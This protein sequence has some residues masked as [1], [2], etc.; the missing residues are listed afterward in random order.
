MTEL[1]E[2]KIELLTH[3]A[4]AEAKAWDSLSRKERAGSGSLL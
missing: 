1:E 3:M 4:D 2:L